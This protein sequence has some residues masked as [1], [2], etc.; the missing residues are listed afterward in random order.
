MR[1]GY[2]AITISLSGLATFIGH[3]RALL[4]VPQHSKSEDIVKSSGL[5]TD[6]RISSRILRLSRRP[7]RGSKSG[8]SLRSLPFFDAGELHKLWRRLVG[9]LF[10]GS[11][12]PDG[13]SWAAI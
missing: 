8:E 2:L 6:L 7:L 1:G 11:S 12:Q 10:R 5:I 13:F 3:M 9:M 4:L